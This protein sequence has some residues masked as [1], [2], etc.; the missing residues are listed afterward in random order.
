MAELAR[1]RNC[2]FVRSD[3]CFRNGQSHS[4]TAHQVSLVP[5]AIE[6]I[7]D[8]RL[9]KIIDAVAVICHAHGRAPRAA[10]G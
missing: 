3:D 9:L 5:P 7:E 10:A 6:L 1:D 4:R 2:A 8:E